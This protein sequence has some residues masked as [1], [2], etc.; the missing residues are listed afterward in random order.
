MSGN[1]V[2]GRGV[3]E[4]RA[5][6]MREGGRRGGINRHAIVR[7]ERAAAQLFTGAI[8]VLGD[9][10]ECDPTSPLSLCNECLR[11]WAEAAR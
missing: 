1:V 7:R 9:H 5:E 3:M 11:L 4:A 10:S 2:V 6:Q 8:V